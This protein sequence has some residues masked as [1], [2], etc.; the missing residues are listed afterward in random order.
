M[1][2]IWIFFLNRKLAARV[3]QWLER[4]K[5]TSTDP[6]VGGSNPP[7]DMGCRSFG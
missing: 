2:N 1:P 5:Q 3:V 4:R 6:Y 7:W